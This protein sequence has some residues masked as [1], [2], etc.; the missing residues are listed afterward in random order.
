MSAWLMGGILMAAALIAAFLVYAPSLSGDFVFDDRSLPMFYTNAVAIPLRAWLG[1]RPLL[2]ATF[3]FSFHTSGL[4]TTGYHALNVILH[5]G[6]A[7]LVFFAIRRLLE[8]A[9]ADA[10]KRTGVAAFGAGLF[11]LHP[12]QTEAVSYIASRSETLSVLLFLAAFNVFLYRRNWAI[13]VKTSAIVL[14]LYG[15]AMSCKE[16]TAMLPAALLLTD[17][18]FNPGFSTAGIRR[19]WKLYVPIGI[20][21][22]AGLFYFSTYIV[23]GSNL[24]FG[25]KG[26]SAYDYALTEF[27]AL[28]VYFRLFVLPYGQ[29][30]DYSFPI[31]HSLLDQGAIFYGIA[32]LALI[33]AAFYYRKRYPLACYGFLLALLLFA[34][35]SS[36]LPIKDPLVERRMY[37]PFIGLAL[38]ACEAALQIPWRRNRLNAVL[39]MVCVV[40]GILTFERNG[41]WTGMEALWRDV[42]SK[43]PRNTRALMGLADA[44]ALRGQCGEAIPYFQRAE[45]LEP[46]DYRNTYNLASAYDCVNQEEAAIAGYKKAIGIKPSADAWAHLAMIQMKQSQ[47]DA[48]YQSLDKAQQL[49][50][51]Y[52][53][54]YT[55]RGI[56]NLAFAKFDLAEQQ[57]RSVLAADPQNELAL[58][59]VAHAQ[60]H[61]RQF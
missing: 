10:D 1:V 23:A 50:P 34:P 59:G 3:Y 16:H 40:F 7:V 48:A 17:Y 26:L 9:N 30:V 6:C 13:D 37:L 52:L 20:A 41:K 42:V 49:D 38:I 28:F 53:L 33:A 51:A 39:A 45:R 25:M 8:W 58:R 12:V 57:F 44:Y 19:N 21:G 18:F 60:K 5:S 2:M 46:S 24:G 35:T 43:E 29:S 15:C 14:V 32:L 54:T 11:L 31:S 56:L 47:F 22:V 61:E 27:R 36:L 4:D 55:Y